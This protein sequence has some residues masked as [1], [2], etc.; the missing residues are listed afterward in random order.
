[1]PHPPTA[2]GF[3]TQKPFN[4]NMWILE[5]SCHWWARCPKSSLGGLPCPNMNSGLPTALA[6]LFRARRE[7]RSQGRQAYLG[8]F[9]FPS[10][11]SLGAFFSR[12]TMTSGA[13]T[14]FRK[15]FVPQLDS[16][17]FQRPLSELRRFSLTRMEFGVQIIIWRMFYGVKGSSPTGKCGRASAY[18]PS[19]NDKNLKSNEL[20]ILLEKIGQHEILKSESPEFFLRSWA[21]LPPCWHDEL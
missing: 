10:K 2:E 4:Q 17:S 21:A 14:E 7:I 12:Q 13:R 18:S 3:A 6:G 11:L 15:L 1:M 9:C 8:D 20:I 19:L 5:V 16:D